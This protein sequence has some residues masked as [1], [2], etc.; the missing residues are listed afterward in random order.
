MNEKSGGILVNVKRENA[1]QAARGWRKLLKAA[2]SLL[3]DKE[4]IAVEAV[5][6]SVEKQLNR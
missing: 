1:I 6:K 5:L 3:T 2:Q 4:A